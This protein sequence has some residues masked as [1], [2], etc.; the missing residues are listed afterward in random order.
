MNL[1]NKQDLFVDYEGKQIHSLVVNGQ[2]VSTIHF[3]N[4]FLLIKQ[5][6]LNKGMNSIKIDFSNPYATDGEGLHSFVDT[7]GQQ[8]LY[9]HLEPAYARR[10]IPCLDQPDLKGKLSLTVLVPNDWTCIS[11]QP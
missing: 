3:N 5:H 4:Y 2:Q 8:Y 7:D 9:T 1:A 11:N 10:W 6:W